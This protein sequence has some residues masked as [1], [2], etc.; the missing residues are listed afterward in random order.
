MKKNIAAIIL[1]ALCCRADGAAWDHPLWLGR[2]EIWRARFPVVITNPSAQ[3]LEG[4]PVAVVVGNAAG[5]APLAG[6]R[7]EALRVTDARGVQ[8]LFGLRDAASRELITA[9]AIPD[10]ATLALPAVCGP[11]TSVTYNVYFDNPGAWGL[12][13]FYTDSPLIDVNGDFEGGAEGKPWGWRTWGATDRHRLLWSDEQPA[14]GKRCLKAEVAA[15]AEP[16]WFGFTRSDIKVLP[17]ANCVIRVRVRGQNVVGSAGWY[18]HVGDEK[19]P[20]RINQVVSAGEGTFGWQEVTITFTVPEGAT[21]LA[22]GSVLRGLGTAW[23][24]DFRFET[25]LHPPLAEARA[26][27][28]ERLELREEGV[29][30]SWPPEMSAATRRTS[31]WLD[32]LRGKKERNREWLYRFP[33]RVINIRP[34]PSGK[35]LA[36]VNLNDV[37]RGLDEP[38]FQLTFKGQPVETCRLSNWLLFECDPAPLTVLTYYLYVAESDAAPHSE[39]AAI[40]ALGSDIPSDQILVDRADKSDAA[41][42][43]KLLRSPVNL[44]RNPDFGEGG[45][46]PA[47]WSGGNN[48]DTIT[49]G[50]SSPGLFGE[51]HVTLS[52]APE[53][54]AAWHG[55]HQSV[56][57]STG[58]TYLYG[59]WLS[60]ENLLGNAS[61]H[62]HLRDSSNRTSAAGY[63]SAGPAISGTSAW[64]PMFGM[65]TATTDIRQF[66]MHL[67]MESRGTLKHDGAFLAECLEAYLGDPPPPPLK[68]DTLAVWPVD[69]LV[70]VFYETPA[71]TGRAVPRAAIA[72]ARNEEEPLQLAIRAGRDIP[73]LRV[74]VEAPR[75]A[76]GHVLDDFSVGWLGYVPIDHRTSYYSMHTP[77]WELK[78]PTGSGASDGWPGWWPDPI[79]PVAAGS[80]TAN[81]TQSIWLSFKARPQ[82]PAGLYKG[83]VKLVAGRRVLKRIPFT[84]QVWDFSL[85]QRPTV[86]AM[87]DL[88]LNEHWFA[89]GRSA[90]EHH[91][92]LMDFMADKKVT[93]D[94]F[95]SEL[96]F[97][98]GA[99]GRVTCDFTA[100]D[101]AARRYFDELGFAVAY[102]PDF[103]YLF[104]WE[105]PP[106][107]VLGEKPYEGEYPY[108]DADRAKLRPAYEAAYQECLRLYWQHVKAQG[109]ADRL[110]LYISDEPFLTKKHIIDQM[111]ALCEMIHAVDP[112]IRIYC[113]T[114]NHCPAWNG[115]L[116]IWGV[117]H[118]GCFPVAEMEARR[119]A[120]DSIWFTTDG[121]MCTDTPF[122]AVERL[123]PHYCFKYGAEAY[124]FWGVSW[125]TYDPWRFGWHRYIHQSSTPG[126]HYY[127]R[128]PNGDGYLLYPGNPIGVDGPVTTIRLEAARDGVEDHAYLTL[129]KNYA[130]RVGD[131][132]AADLLGEFADLL[133]IPNAGGRF[134]TKI[135][136]DPSRLAGLR[137][138]A[139]AAL[140]RLARAENETKVA[141]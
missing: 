136:P 117:G 34:G 27:D 2:G 47:D 94:R 15:Q 77:A 71:P 129:L 113:S 88:R 79:I 33:V 32:L 125:F 49:F 114:W 140:E 58:R 81:R 56:P 10:G 41:A 57:V 68:V 76:Q 14:S 139:G 122:C 80:L 115:H 48:S 72:L 22:T 37:K 13:D 103:F 135:L 116:D 36:C 52:V 51:R 123:L 124:E 55:W 26:G 112:E 101:R 46:L 60:C 83:R 98:R 89:D 50:T 74:E 102:M 43:A 45:D 131:Q 118:Y 61:L 91:D 25:D 126:D 107:H 110:V 30:E 44:M 109:W 128:Y 133:E 90:A 93:P 130:D 21:R 65:F 7:A 40:S 66:Q 20:Q 96:A 8:L 73:E 42:F 29:E 121:Q 75:S 17:G 63:L 106:K 100:H 108:A 39:R 16:T 105:H 78:F 111:Q 70:K 3:P 84:V 97:K 137:L 120:G 59:A 4:V 28:V 127:V 35:L 1:S 19:N 18:V 92:R 38:R 64:R 132:A 12:A 6:A 24:D 138:R 62:A 31:R 54:P 67:T 141:K 53:A 9:G 85:P 86:T 99:D 87:Y 5:Q 104:G 69:P 119:A 11:L 82:T 23:Y 134:S 95:R